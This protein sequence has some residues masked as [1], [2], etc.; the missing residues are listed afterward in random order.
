M[1]TQSGREYIHTYVLQINKFNPPL[2]IRCLLTWTGHYGSFGPWPDF[3]P[4]RT[5]KE[6]EEIAEYLSWSLIYYTSNTSQMFK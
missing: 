3:L 4:F 6:S 5:A 1:E 2:A